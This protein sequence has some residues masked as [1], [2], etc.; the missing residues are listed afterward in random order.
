MDNEK[1]AKAIVALYSVIAQSERD[2]TDDE[3]LETC[4][5]LYEKVDLYPV[6]FSWV[7]LYLGLSGKPPFFIKCFA[8]F[9][10]SLR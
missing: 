6:E 8:M 5:S 4:F 1:L 9:W 10:D 2:D 3:L 7:C